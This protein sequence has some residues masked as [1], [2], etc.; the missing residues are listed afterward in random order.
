M[1]RWNWWTTS[2]TN[3]K[4][5][6]VHSYWHVTMK[7]L[8]IPSL[9]RTFQPHVKMTLTSSKQF[10]A[11]N[12]HFPYFFRTNTSKVINPPNIQDK[13][14]LDKWASLNKEMDSLAKAYLLY[15]ESYPELD[16]T[17]DMA[18]WAIRIDGRKICKQFKQ[19][20]AF[21]LRMRPI[22]QLWTNTPTTS[23][24]HQ[25]PK[26]L[27]TQFHMI[28]TINTQKAWNQTRGCIYSFV[29]CLSTNSPQ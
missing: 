23:H 13:Q 21:H 5:D 4:S 14:I 15:S 28:N 8:D 22:Q 7:Q 12:V 16:D 24:R 17:I 11:P 25:T 1:Q 6:Q 2:A 9:K 18:E 10:R 19:Q 27:T 29:K 26:Y 20:L 3:F